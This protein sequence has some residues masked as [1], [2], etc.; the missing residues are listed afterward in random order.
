[1]QVPRTPQQAGWFHLG[2]SPG[3][4]GPA[5]IL[6]HVDSWRGPGVF[7]TLETLVP[8]DLLDVTLADCVVVQFSVTS[9]QTY[10]KQ[11]FPAARVYGPHC[12]SAL[13]LVTCGGGFDSATGS[14]LSNVVVYSTLRG[15]TPASASAPASVPI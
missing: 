14:Y 7:F 9:V 8:G 12:V 5:I 1:M 11:S 13:Q 10:L 6:G 15:T 3:E 4:L 2:P